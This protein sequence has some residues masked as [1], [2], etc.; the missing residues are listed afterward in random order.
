[1][2]QV[3]GLRPLTEADGQL[4]LDGE[5]RQCLLLAAARQQPPAQPPTPHPL[6]LLSSHPPLQVLIKGKGRPSALSGSL[7]LRFYSWQSTHPCPH[8]A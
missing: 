1:M 7:C 8:Q 2:S 3:L 4:S 5:A 6:G